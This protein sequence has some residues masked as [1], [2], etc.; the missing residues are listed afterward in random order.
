V[1][2]DIKKNILTPCLWID[3]TALDRGKQVLV[4]FQCIYVSA[5]LYTLVWVSTLIKN[6][7][8][9]QKVNTSLICKGADICCFYDAIPFI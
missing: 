6:S 7:G 9:L 8:P 4:A 1:D 2:G 5:L 3:S